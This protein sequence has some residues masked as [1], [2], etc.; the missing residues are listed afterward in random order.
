VVYLTLSNA[1]PTPERT[2]AFE[3]RLK[4]MRDREL[5]LRPL[6][7]RGIL[8]ALAFLEIQSHRLEAQ[9]W[10]TRERARELPCSHCT[11]NP[12]APLPDRCSPSRL[13]QDMKAS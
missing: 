7:E 11:Q 9:F 3:D 5:T 13:S 12:N 2:T 8:S 1:A 6:Y 10:L 4:R